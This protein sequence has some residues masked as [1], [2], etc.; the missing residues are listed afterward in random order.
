LKPSFGMTMQGAGTYEI[1]GL[2]WSGLGR[3]RRLE[4]SADGGRSWADAA[5]T[6]P[7]MPKAL[8]RFRMAWMWNGGPA[9][10]LS[11][12]TDD[13]GRVQPMRSAWLAQYAPRQNYHYNAINAWAVGADG[14]V[15][16]TYV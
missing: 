16:H 4:V 7:V 13:K 9:T 15:S 8:T 5:L 11:R 1:S 10:L 12:T 2:A 14:R 6:E 3:V